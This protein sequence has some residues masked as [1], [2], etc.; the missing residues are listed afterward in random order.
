MIADYLWLKLIHVLVAVTVLGAGFGAGLVLQF[1]G[2]DRAQG[3]YLLELARKLQLYVAFPG[4]LLMLASGM[5]LGHVANLL[6]VHWTEAAMNVWGAGA[7]FMGLSVVSLRKRI[8]LLETLGPA[9]PAYRRVSLWNRV[10][11]AAAGLVIVFIV[12]LMVMKPG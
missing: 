8:R 1:F 2:D 7:L 5:W 11:G 9:S 6:D 4:Y 12:Y 10:V 3:P